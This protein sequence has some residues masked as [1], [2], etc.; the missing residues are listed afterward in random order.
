MEPFVLENA[1][2]RL[3]VPTIED[4]D[5]IY[6][7]CRTDKELSR[8]TTIP[9]PYST[10]DAEWYIANAAK[11]WASGK[12]LTWAVRNPRGCQGG[13]FDQSGA[14]QVARGVTDDT[15]PPI[16]GT[17]DLRFDDAPPGLVSGSIGYAMYP[18]A[19]GRGLMTEAVRLVLDWGFS[20]EGGNMARATWRALV[21]NWPSRR[22]AWKA[23]FRVEGTLRSELIDRGKLADAW[24]G[25]LMKGDPL[26]PNEPWIGQ[27]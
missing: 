10:A 5:D 25:T 23:G 2:V 7:Y 27:S 17:I 21:G 9:Q 12:M 15:E 1:R 6:H 11:G 20:T 22:V 26:A 8:W 3:S 19:R 13:G 14:L 4:I 18:P 24:L 16:L